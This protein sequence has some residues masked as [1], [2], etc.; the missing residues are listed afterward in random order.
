MNNIILLLI[1]S[2]TYFSSQ[3]QNVYG[4]DLDSMELF[5]QENPEVYPEI[6][7]RFIQN[8]TSL[9][10]FDHMFLYYGVA[11]VEGYAPYGDRVISVAVNQFLEDKNY[12]EAERLLLNKV[13][14][15]PSC[16]QCYYDLGVVYY[17][18]QDSALSELHFEK[19]RDLL[20]VP[21]FSGNGL[22]ADS[23]FIVSSIDDEY[24]IMSEM[25]FKVMGQSLIS[26]KEMS[27]D[28]LKGKK[29]GSEEIVEYYF[30]I[31]LP[32]GK[33]LDYLVEPKKKKSK[34][35]KKKKKKKSDSQ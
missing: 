29:E 12:E 23:A 26:H 32:F 31:E 7:Q 33:T 34:K 28:V 6:G 14:N 19:Y 2:F 20:S 24:L 11:F 16:V 4:F 5:I 13:R 3:A 25:G 30:N 21:F 15:L 22:S 1:F 10:P 35:R 8:D 9:T 17:Y 27:F 18:T